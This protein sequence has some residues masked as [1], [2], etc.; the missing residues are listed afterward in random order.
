MADGKVQCK[1]KIA[2]TKFVT[3]GAIQIVVK[4]Y[5]N[6]K[7]YVGIGTYLHNEIKIKHY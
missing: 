2:K 6:S 4:M 5:L 3:G 7:K 1:S